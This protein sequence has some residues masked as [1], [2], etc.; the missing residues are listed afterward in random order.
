MRASPSE[1]S[2]NDSRKIISEYSTMAPEKQVKLGLFDSAGRVFKKIG[3]SGKAFVNKLNPFSGKME[4]VYGKKAV[5]RHA[6]VVKSMNGIPMA[7]RPKAETLRR[8]RK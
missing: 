7:N 5:K 2:V 3:K 4:K 8:L 6:G 1:P